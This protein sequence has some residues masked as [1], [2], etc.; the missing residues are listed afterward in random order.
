MAEEFRANNLINAL[1]RGCRLPWFVT[2]AIFAV[3]L[4]SL[5]VLAAYLD[6]I[7]TVLSN[8]LF[9]RELLDSPVMTIYILVVYPFV[10]RL[11]ERAIQAI[12]PLLSEDGEFERMLKQ[13]IEPKRRWEWTALLAGAVFWLLVSQPWNANWVPGEFWLHVYEIITFPILFGLLGWLIYDSLKGARML[14][15]LSHQELN[16]DIF[17]GGVLSPIAYYSLSVSLAFIGGISLSLVFQTPKSLLM[18]NNI[19]IYAVLVGA[20]ILIFFL[21][22]WSAHN[23]MARVKR[24]EL[25]MVRRQLAEASRELKELTA[26][27]QL[28]GMEGL[29]SAIAGWVTYE[30][31]VQEAPSWPFN[32]SIIRRLMASVLVPAIVYLIKI[33]SGLGL[34]L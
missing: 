5:L 33:L 30:R 26:Q 24:G 14:G 6:G 34:R 19:T 15:R 29:S 8:W 31:R 2:T 9:W 10:R 13:I 16:L 3:V 32:A 21:S 23:A 28:K 22:M 7:L 1:M 4:I 11:W 25:S 20:T 27:G 18:W 17:D 12:Q